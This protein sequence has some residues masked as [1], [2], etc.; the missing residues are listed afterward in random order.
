MALPEAVADALYCEANRRLESPAVTAARVIAESLPQY[1]TR[2]LERD[3]C[4]VMRDSPAT[5]PDPAP[6]APGG[7]PP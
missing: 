3:L 1:V 5:P 4:T 7:S 6:T 2:A